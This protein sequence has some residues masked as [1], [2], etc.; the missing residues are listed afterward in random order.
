MKCVKK[1]KKTARL[2]NG[3]V[4]RKAFRLTFFSAFGPNRQ[5]SNFT[6]NNKVSPETDL[7]LD[8]NF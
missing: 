3:V 8:N 5:R 7:R 2:K 1:Y 4:Q 6:A